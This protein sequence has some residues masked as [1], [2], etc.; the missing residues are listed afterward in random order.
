MAHAPSKVHIERRKIGVERLRRRSGRSGAFIPILAPLRGRGTLVNALAILPTQKRRVETRRCTQKCV[1]HD[2]NRGVI[3]SWAVC[4]GRAYGTNSSTRTSYFTDSFGFSVTIPV[5][6]LP[7][8]ILL[9][10]SARLNCG[11][12]T[13]ICRSG[14]AYTWNALTCGE[15]AV[16]RMPYF[17]AGT[18]QGSVAVRN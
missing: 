4:Y 1:R 10:G 15:T 6:T 9:Y 17:A 2:G 18:G 5:L 8:Q 12:S 7:P 3:Y 16:M 11:S 14:G 13:T